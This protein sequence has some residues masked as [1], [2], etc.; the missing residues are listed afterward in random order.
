LWEF[1][2]YGKPT[3]LNSIAIMDQ[4]AQTDF[5]I[6][7]DDLILVTG[8]TGFV[9]SKVVESLLDRGFRN[10]RCF[11]RP[12][13]EAE[14]IQAV[15]ALQ[16][17]GSGVQ[18]FRGNLL[19]RRDCV[20]ATKGVVVILHLAAGRGEKFYPDAFVNSVVTTR[21]LLDACVQ[22]NCLKRFVNVSS[23][24][25]YTNTNKNRRNLLDEDCPI[26]AHP[27][28]RGEAYCFAKVK[29]DEIVAEYGRRH[30]IPYVMVRPGHVYGSGNT[31]I[32]GRVGIDTF[33]VFLHL[34][35]S[36]PIPLTYVENCA[37][38]I[39]LAGLRRGIDG[40]A[41]NVVDDDLPSS[42][43]F[44]RLYKRNVGHFTS[45][46]FPHLVSY[47]LCYLWE[48]YSN[49]SDGQLPPAFNRKRWHAFWKKTQYSN[50]K[51]KTRLGWTPKVPT[52][53]GLQ[54]YFEACRGEGGHA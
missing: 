37:D 29:Q 10:I 18:I 4:N 5:L 2:L 20:A 7:P 28:R 6:G 12:S 25:V 1:I 47:S 17:S 40:E 16:N 49:W 50:Q 32:S 26:E 22:H 11:T 34:G 42:R 30:G 51:L 44:L 3:L 23:F 46:F 31:A 9:G 24:L 45:V 8:A 38:A 39:V 27:E 52:T 41:F 36:N 53:E 54:R 14:K 33:G 15:F 13:S 21:N 35:G 43:Q 19:S 48:K